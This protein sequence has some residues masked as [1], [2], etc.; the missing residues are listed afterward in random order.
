M[1]ILINLNKLIKNVYVFQVDSFGFPTVE[2]LV[3]IYSDG[4]K[5][6]N[7]KLVTLRGVLECLGTAQQRHVT[8]IPFGKINMNDVVG[9]INLK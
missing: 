9:V 1:I 2:G 7:Y 3:R 8:K 6:Q 5:D 4:V